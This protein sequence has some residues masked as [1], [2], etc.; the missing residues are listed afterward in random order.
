MRDF[1]RLDVWKKSHKLTLAIYRATAVY[2]KEETYGLVSQTRRAAV[3]IAANIAEGY[4]AESDQGFARYLG[5]AISSSSELEY[6]LLLAR[7]L[8]YIQDEEHQKL[9]ARIASVQPMLAKLLLKL[10]ADIGASKV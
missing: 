8:A 1:K 10:R 3:S 4:G 9:A 2:P 7:D 6:H 5:M